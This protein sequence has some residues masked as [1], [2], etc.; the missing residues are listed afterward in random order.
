MILAAG[1]SVRTRESGNTTFDEGQRAS[2][3][4]S[5]PLANSRVDAAAHGDGRIDIV[6]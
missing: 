4:R 2:F 5:L 3:D 1:G 6:P